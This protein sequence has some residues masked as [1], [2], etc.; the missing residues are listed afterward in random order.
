[1]IAPQA[2]RSIRGK[3]T[4]IMML[5]SSAGLLLA[6]LAIGISDW[7]QFRG[8]QAHD[9]QVMARILGANTTSALEF[10]DHEFADTALR[11]LEAQSNI[12]AARIYTAEGQPF[13]SV[14]RGTEELPPR[15]YSADAYVFEQGTLKLWHT[16]RSNDRVVGS[17][18]L[19]SD[20][21]YVNERLTRHIMILAIVLLGCLLVTFL[22]ASRLQRIIS[23]P[24]LELTRGAHAVS[25]GRDYSVR[26]VRTS[27]DEVGILIS[28]FNEMLNQIQL[29]D[30]QLA[31]HSDQLESEVAERTTDLVEVNAKL[32]EQ[33]ER[34]EAATLAKSRFLANMSHEIRTPMN[35]VLGMSGLLLETDLDAEQR[36]L[37]ETV[38]RSADSLLTI[39]N[40][41]LDFSKIEA[42][43]LELDLLDFDLRAAVEETVD[44]MAQL[45]DAKG[46][47]LT[48]FVATDIPRFMRGDAG[49]LRQ[50]ILNLLSNAVKFTSEGE[51]ILRVETEA[52]DDEGI[53]VVFQVQD[54]GIGIPAARRDSLFGTFTQVDSSTTRKYG[55][56]GLGLA[57]SRQLVELMG[58]VIDVQSVEGEGSTFWFTVQLG[59]PSIEPETVEQP[60]DCFSNLRVLIVDDSTTNRKLLG[61]LLASWGCGYEEA[62]D[63]ETALERIRESIGEGRPFDL[64]LVDLQMPRMDGEQLAR[65]VKADTSM[66]GLDLILLTS[67]TGLGNTARLAEIGFRGY[68]TKPIKQSML[69]NSIAAVVHAGDGSP[70]PT[71]AERPAPVSVPAPL[72][73]HG[74]RVL[75]AEDNVVNQR[76]ADRILTRLGYRSEV[77]A[78]GR[79]ALQALARTRFDIVLMDCQMPEM[80]G[81]E[82][83][84]AV[85][86]REKSTGERMPIIAMTAN[87]M[88]GDRELCLE[89][90]MDD[91]IAK[92]VDSNALD[93]LIEKWT[94]NPPASRSSGTPLDREIMD[95]L[96]KVLAGG[97]E[98]LDQRIDTFLADA[99][100][101]LNAIEAAA[102]AHDHDEL[103]HGA[104]MLHARCEDLA[105][106]RLSGLLFELEVLARAAADD[107]LPVAVRRIRGETQLVFRALAMERRR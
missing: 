24:I 50:V 99:P 6:S 74:V 83:T 12:L 8:V 79:E 22:L 28:A 84:R 62:E 31:R 61:R 100:E 64:A 59:H 14:N 93:A 73:R 18:F 68:L 36:E 104:R 32:R 11:V 38:M 5:T 40:D 27:D 57:I 42:G 30:R 67:I 88:S 103:I 96:H 86:D 58:G 87:A 25:V 92:P 2:H 21:R 76:V 33:S 71:P 101:L 49:R 54:T 105:A 85:R 47:E 13:A 9:L 98:S 55:G 37:A 19:H 75:V 10:Q 63:G 29:R 91:Y 94:C 7:I 20:P 26:A 106:L 80:D 17:V 1:M 78:N 48:C 77:A 82:A 95:T 102:D 3:L 107:A 70:E 53:R 39:I 60:Q 52:S 41:I 34:A 81:F 97:G 72:D 89:A 51:V 15:P 65:S 35:G 66:R 56:T 69:F 23:N 45:V 46:L 43:K 44:L 90:G 16:I 4:R